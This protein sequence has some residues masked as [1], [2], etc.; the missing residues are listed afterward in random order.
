M[1][2]TSKFYGSQPLSAWLKPNKP[3]EGRPCNDQ[4]ILLWE[5]L[6]R[7]PQSLLNPCAHVTCHARTMHWC[8]GAMV[9]APCM[10]QSAN[11]LRKFAHFVE[12]ADVLDT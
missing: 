3:N 5:F 12:H 10:M 8:I 4:V 9:H 6:S 11:F 2:N 7:S 1:A